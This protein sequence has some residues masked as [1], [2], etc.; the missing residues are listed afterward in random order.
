[1]KGEDQEQRRLQAVAAVRVATDALAALAVHAVVTGSLARG[2]FRPHSDIDLL[3]IDCP[4]HVKY[5]IEGSWTTLWPV[6]HF[7]VVYLDEPTPWKAA[8]FSERTVHA[9]QLR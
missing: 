5:A 2:E 8:R 7:D 6:S 4:Q 9:F 1:M 3:V